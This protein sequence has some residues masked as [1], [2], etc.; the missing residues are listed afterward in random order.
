MV[1]LQYL[2]EQLVFLPSQQC[3]TFSCCNNFLAR[4]SPPITHTQTENII[5]TTAVFV[6]N[7]LLQQHDLEH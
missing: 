4:D 7:S 3:I 1:T 6:N 2:N 5:Y